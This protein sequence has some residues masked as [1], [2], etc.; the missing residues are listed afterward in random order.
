MPRHQA[1]ET[2]RCRY[3]FRVIVRDHKDDPWRT[4]DGFI[5]CRP[6]VDVSLDL[7]KQLHVA[8]AP[9]VSVFA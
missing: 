7:E 5:L 1:S 8:G 9:M 4:L 2:D 6:A 3:C